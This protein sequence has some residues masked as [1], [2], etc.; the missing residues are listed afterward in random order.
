VVR[1]QTERATEAIRA[2]L[3]EGIDAAMNRFNAKS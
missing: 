3:S 2:I 1:E